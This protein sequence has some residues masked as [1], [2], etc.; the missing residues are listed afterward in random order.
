MLNYLTASMI[1]YLM[2]DLAQYWI[3]YHEKKESFEVC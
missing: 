1:K 3:Y 2:A